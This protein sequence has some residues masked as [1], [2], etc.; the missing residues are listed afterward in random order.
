MTRDKQSSSAQMG[1]VV[2][3]YSQSPYLT[4]VRWAPYLFVTKG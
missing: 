3:L 4:F 2:V 1:E